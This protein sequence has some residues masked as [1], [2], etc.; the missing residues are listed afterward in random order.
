MQPKPGQQAQLASHEG[1]SS[2]LIRGTTFSTDAGDLRLSWLTDLAGFFAAGSSPQGVP[3]SAG[4]PSG[5]AE[6]GGASIVMDMAWSVGLQDIAVRYEASKQCL[7]DATVGSQ[8]EQQQEQQRQQQQPG[9]VQ[10]AVH[11]QPAAGIA[12]QLQ[13]QSRHHPHRHRHAQHQAAASQQSVAETQL[14]QQQSRSQDTRHSNCQPVQQGDTNPRS[15]SNGSQLSDSATQSSVRHQPEE[16]PVSAVLTL[17]GLQWGLQPGNDSQ[18]ICLQCIS[19]YCADSASCEGTWALTHPV[20]MCTLQLAES[21]YGLIGQEAQLII[22]LKPPQDPADGFFETE[23]TNQH[24]GVSVTKTQLQLVT[25]LSSQISAQQ[26]SSSDSSSIPAAFESQ[27]SSH[28]EPDA[29]SGRGVNEG[30]VEWEGVA[31]EGRL[32]VMEGVQEDAFKRY[33][34]H[35]MQMAQADLKLP[36]VLCTSFHFGNTNYVMHGVQ[37]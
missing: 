22:A 3:P 28:D 24:M 32:R 15:N 11:Q 17:A 19:L 25:R 29:Q 23:V 16:M 13:S 31:G 34:V 33:A 18:Q 7:L 5:D 14:R 26:S 12:T 10:S 1:Q 37:H 4:S 2:A 36:C 20:D 30:I 35:A 6:G 27:R 8:S 9:H 21:G